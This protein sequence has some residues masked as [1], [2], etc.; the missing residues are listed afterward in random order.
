M[1]AFGPGVAPVLPAGA[2]THLSR[3]ESVRDVGTVA[4]VLNQPI[5]QDGG[6]VYDRYHSV[7][8]GMKPPGR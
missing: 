7:V 8:H 1:Q 6:G 3:E 2:S 4:H 5:S